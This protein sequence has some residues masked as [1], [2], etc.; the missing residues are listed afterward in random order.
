[1]LIFLAGELPYS[2]YGLKP[3]NHDKLYFRACKTTKQLN[4]LIA[5]N[6]LGGNA[7]KDFR[8]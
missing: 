6:I 8:L 5:L 4:T 7:R 3:H 2:F 1:M